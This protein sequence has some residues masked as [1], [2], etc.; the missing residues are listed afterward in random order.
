MDAIS[1]NFGTTPF[2]PTSPEAMY[3]ILYAMMS[4]PALLQQF[5]QQNGMYG[6]HNPFAGMGLPQLPPTTPTNANVAPSFS[7]FSSPMPMPTMPSQQNFASLQQN[8]APSQQNFAP[9]QQNFAPSQ[10]NLTPSQQN[11]APPQQNLSSFQQS[12]HTSPVVRVFAMHANSPTPPLMPT[13]QMAYN[14][15]GQH[16][17]LLQSINNFPP[18]KPFLTSPGPNRISEPAPSGLT[19]AP[20]TDAVASP[21]TPLTAQT[22]VAGDPL[23]TDVLGAAVSNASPIVEHRPDLAVTSAAAAQERSEP[24][25]VSLIAAEASST[26][27]TARPQRHRRVPINPDGTRPTNLP[28]SRSSCAVETGIDLDVPSEVPLKR[29]TSDGGAEC[30]KR[31]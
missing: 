6:L 28:G 25:S 15:S 17:S 24:A 12:L 7:H 14:T 8:F 26:P 20:Q 18:G 3:P 2:M 1:Q 31:K 5:A 16:A 4:Q 13:A 22:Q 27:S 30:R 9:S 23:D 19:Y 21:P 29:K 11:F 10:Q